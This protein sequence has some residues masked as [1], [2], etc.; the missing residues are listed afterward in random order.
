M[1]NTAVP[2]VIP[3]AEVGFLISPHGVEA[4]AGEVARRP[5]FM[6]SRLLYRLAGA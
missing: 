4:D 5:V 2:L 3:I 6:P 1:S